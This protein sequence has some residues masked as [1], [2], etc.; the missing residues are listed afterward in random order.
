MQEKISKV[1]ALIKKYTQNQWFD[2]IIISVIILFGFFW[3]GVTYQQYQQYAFRTGDTP[4][5]EQAI[6]NTVHGRFLYQSFLQTDTNLRE[7][8]S[9]IQLLYVP[10]YAIFPH[11]L[12]LFFIIQ[13]SF[14]TSLIYL[15]RFVRKKISEVAAIIAVCLFIFNPL[16]AS[17]VVGDM[18]VVSIAG[19]M[20]LMMLIAYYEKKYRQ[21]LF[22]TVSMVLVSEFV[23]PTV[24]LVGVLALIERRS[25]RWYVPPIAGGVSL[26]MA[27]KYYITI[28]FGSNE[29]IVSKFAPQA[30]MSIYK[31]EKRLGLV[32]EALAPLL[33]IFPWMSIY[34]ILLIPSLLIALVII[35]PG[36]IGGG[37][38]VFI[39]I[40]PILSLIFIDLLMR[41][42]SYRKFIYSIAIIGIIISLHPWWK[43]MEV[44]G[45]DLTAEMDRAVM[46]IKDGGSLTASTQFGPKVNRRE[47]FFLPMNEKMTDYVILKTS[48]L[49]KNKS[50]LADQE[51]K[52]DQKLE[53]SGLYRVI[54]K[55]GRV[56]VYVKK[57][58]ICELL[59]IS[60]NQLDH[61]GDVELQ[62]MWKNVGTND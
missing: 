28:G 11:T 10:L 38:H 5:A 44:D 32:R 54:F 8:I 60:E 45:S 24:A 51:L 43:W 40:P 61:I 26:Y 9:F 22:W 25:W 29:N 57:I 3:F 17:Q 50:E 20:F 58:K 4:V 30:L 53:T 37:N 33:W 18:H 59:S 7:H 21:F 16:T 15:Y 36:R 35:I 48:K 39:L 46:M 49:V 1:I 55:E 23:A 19:P 47:E 13:I 12:T 14:V 6:W 62:S 42:R 31:I 2:R 41:F 27:A 52:Y 34:A 56:I